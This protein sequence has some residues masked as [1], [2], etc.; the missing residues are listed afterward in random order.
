[1]GVASTV[2]LTGATGFVGGH[3]YAPLRAAGHRVLCASRDPERARRRAPD[4][5][6]VGVDFSDD[7]SLGRALEGCRAA[8]Y[9]V[10]SLAEGRKSFRE[11]EVDA[12]ERFAAR[13]AMAGVERI[14]YLGGIAP[15]GRPSEHLGSR[16]DVGEA[17]RSGPVT[18][19]ELRASMIIGH[20]SL[21]WRV[22]RDLAAR[23]PGM[24]LPKWLH[25]RTEPVGI[26]D[27]MVALVRGLDVALEGSASFDLPGP[28]IM[29]GRDL[30]ERTAKVLG[31]REP[32]VVELPLLSPWIASQW[33]RFVTGADFEMA[34]KIV[35]GLSHDVL[36]RDDRYWH[37][38]GHTNLQSFEEAAEKA[39]AEEDQQGEG[40]ARGPW[41]RIERGLDRYWH[42]H[43]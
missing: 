36:A 39:L 14:I 38:I 1:M 33:V 22:V 26:E 32:I 2:L 24:V 12:A 29:S 17:L 11:R 9:L 25:S 20:G 41:G 35:V 13:A 23:L 5:D 8:F 21:S 3:L 27:V 28:E 15:R 18:T 42:S 16:L 31:R 10:H 19:L 4:R 43:G 40:E 34:R 7:A 6:W 37:L 30:L